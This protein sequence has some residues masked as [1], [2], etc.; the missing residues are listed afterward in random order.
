MITLAH[1][2]V[3][4]GSKQA[5]LD[6]DVNEENG[7]PN[8]N[9][10][11]N[12]SA[13]YLFDKIVDKY[14]TD[15]LVIGEVPIVLPQ[16]LN[17]AEIKEKIAQKLPE[18]VNQESLKIRSLPGYDMKNDHMTATMTTEVMKMTFKTEKTKYGVYFYG[19]EN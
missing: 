14:H 19:I 2:V 13:A 11:Q 6:S 9:E 17:M 15:M 5:D 18:S 1:L 10:W 4:S 16:N 12:I 7:W 8:N 3:Q